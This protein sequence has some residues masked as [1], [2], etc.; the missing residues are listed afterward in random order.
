M[1]NGSLADAL[2]ASERKSSWD[3]RVGIALDIAK[4]I[5]YLHE[6]CETQI[7]HCDIKPQNILMDEHGNTRISDFGLAKLLKPDQ[8][9]T[10]TGIRGTSGYIAPEWYRKLPVTVK[11]DI[12]SFGIV[13]L[14][15]ICC[16]KCADWSLSKEEAILDE[17]VYNCFEA[18]ELGRLVANEEVDHATLERM[19]K[20]GLWCIQDSP[21]QRPSIKQV[22]LMLQGVVNIPVPPYPVS[23]LS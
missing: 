14:E 2:F 20:V 11:V 10:S 1:S 15:I 5:H 9:K 19:V 3:E 13:L 16:R 23:C 12:Y 21:S 7:I 18:Q 8:T 17:W 4:G 6:E 22:L